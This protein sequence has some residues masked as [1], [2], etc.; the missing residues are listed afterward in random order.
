MDGYNFTYLFLA[1]LFGL[2]EDNEIRERIFLGMERKSLEEMNEFINK[3]ENNLDNNN[4]NIENTMNDEQKELKQRSSLLSLGNSGY[5]L[6][7]ICKQY[8]N[9][10]ADIKVSA[11]KNK[12]VQDLMVNLTLLTRNLSEVLEAFEIPYEM[13]SGI[14]E[15]VQTS[16]KNFFDDYDKDKFKIKPL[17]FYFEKE[18][19]AVAKE[20][21]TAQTLNEECVHYK[22]FEDMG[23]SIPYCE[24]YNIAGIAPC[25]NCSNF[26]SV[27]NDKRSEN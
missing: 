20:N 15:K 26:K 19:N 12:L 17:D 5:N 4:N 6:N 9:N 7:K 16:A 22:L 10:F 1:L 3:G 2:S 23:K 21:E 25:Y 14:L 11:D 18:V 8:F 13:A 24:L 27:I